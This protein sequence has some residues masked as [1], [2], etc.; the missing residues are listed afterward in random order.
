[1]AL[2][3]YRPYTP[4]RRYMTTADFSGLRKVRPVRILTEP[5]NALV[6]QYQ[7]LFE[8]DNIELEFKADAVEAIATEAMKRNTGA[9]GLRAIIED[10]MVNVMY[11]VP[12]RKEVTKCIVTRDVVTKRED[13]LVVTAERKGRKKQEESA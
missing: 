6:K 11:E 2:K 1:M 7:K 4:S 8:L 13:P 5:K 10:I 12:A 3:R 9:R